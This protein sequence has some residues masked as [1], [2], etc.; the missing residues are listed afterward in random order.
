MSTTRPAAEWHLAKPVR[1]V[2]ASLTAEDVRTAHPIGI[3]S[4]AYDGVPHELEPVTGAGRAAFA[5]LEGMRSAAI[6]GAAGI[7]FQQA[8]EPFDEASA[9]LWLDISAA[10]PTI[11]EV[12]QRELDERL[13]AR[14]VA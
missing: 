5:K 6:N 1:A 12:V 11:S 10:V 4:A 3:R 14:E 7:S 8:F 2:L 9:S 13:T